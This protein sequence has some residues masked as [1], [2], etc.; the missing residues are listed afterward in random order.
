MAK[1]VMTDSGPGDG[2][3]VDVER[4]AGHIDIWE[5]DV[6]WRCRIENEN[7]VKKIR[8]SKKTDVTPKKK[9]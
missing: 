4:Y 5:G 1:A 8:W 9:K 7:G 6:L 3:E 2:Q